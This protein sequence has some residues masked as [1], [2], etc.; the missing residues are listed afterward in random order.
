MIEYNKESKK[1]HVCPLSSINSSQ[2]G[3]PDPECVATVATMLKEATSLENVKQDTRE[4]TE[5]DELGNVSKEKEDDL[6]KKEETR[7]APLDAE[8]QARE[9]AEVQEING[10]DEVAEKADVTAEVSPV[11]EREDDLENR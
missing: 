3:K 1:Q 11:K 6:M 7:D 2:D 5:Q 9:D 10:K 4:E 8:T